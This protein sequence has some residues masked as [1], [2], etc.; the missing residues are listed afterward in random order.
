VHQI[1]ILDTHTIN[2]IAAGEVVER[3]SS[4]VKEL[5]ENSIDAKASSITVEIKNGGVD[6]IRVTDNG[7]GIPKEQVEIAFLRHATSKITAAEDLYEV[8][9]LGFRG[10]ALASIAAVSHVEL[11]TKEKEALTGKRVTVSG[12]K[13]NEA[14]E[15]A[16]P[17]GTTFI[18][19]HLFYN[20]PA[21]KAFLN[22]NSSEAAKIS[23]YMYK[24]ALAHPEIAF[25]YIQNT[26]VIF[27]TSGDHELKHCVLN[28]YG[29]EYAKN[30]FQCYY[31]SN[32]IECV[33]LL[34]SPTLNRS[35]RNY[36]HF[37]INGRY[38]KSTILQGA[39]EEAYKTLAMV[40]KFPFIVL[41]LNLDPALVDVNVHPT[42]LQVRFKNVDLIYRIVHDAVAETLKQEYLVPNVD[43]D[44]PRGDTKTHH[45]IETEQLGV[46]TFFTPRKE[47]NEATASSLL[48]GTP[49]Q[50]SIPATNPYK[51]SNKT[52]ERLFGP[53]LS[54]DEADN[55]QVTY[56]KQE[57]DT[58]I[59]NAQEG[60][61]QNY[62]AEAIKTTKTSDNDYDISQNTQ[63]ASHDDQMGSSYIHL[64]EQLHEKEQTRQEV[65]IESQLNQ[66]TKDKEHPIK[67]QA[68]PLPLPYQIIGQLFK[69]YWMIQ[70]GEKIFI[71]DQH[72]AHERV[73]YE[74]FM[75]Y[76]KS[77]EIA[78]QILLMPETLRI[79]PAEKVLLEENEELFTKLGFVYETF[80]ELD[81]VI[82][83]VPYLLNEPI[84]V[85]VFK[86]VLDELSEGKVNHLADVKAENIIRMSCRSAIKGH[87]KLSDEEC[88][89]LIHA[90]MN[91]EN[92]FTCPHG[93]PTIVSLTQADIEK[94]F[95]RI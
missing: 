16:C 45:V 47:N 64:V 7:V 69:T 77:G 56:P 9:S 60:I 39:V 79:T 28:I 76:F 4:V 38:I 5:V 15:I 92:P 74:K 3:P 90:L 26:K 93:R 91:L 21:R 86:D 58:S 52:I 11:L 19:R 2:K 73:L 71:I 49:E 78:T 54:G 10:E 20:V 75:A 88:H 22:S 62:V 35:N 67:E 17:N 57:M 84:N 24:L 66:D 43:L 37:F 36:E 6:L 94:L 82:R 41:H 72:S 40:G 44:K 87:D 32:G 12:G 18:M 53:K 25:K 50:K 29:K 33:G 34:G 63:V 70:Y 89:E 83:E 80:G 95:K 68:S 8:T 1:K 23:D 85:H 51:P 14:E 61:S 55:N 59:Y 81:I 46:D 42:K 13:I 27:T 48:G 30:T 65:M 31:K